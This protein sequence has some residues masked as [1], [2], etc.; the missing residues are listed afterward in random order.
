VRWTRVDCIGHP[1]LRQSC[2]SARWAVGVGEPAMEGA[3]AGAGK[4]TRDGLLTGR[5]WSRALR[6]RTT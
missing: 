2:D 4:S 1:E 5:C 6:G 3:L